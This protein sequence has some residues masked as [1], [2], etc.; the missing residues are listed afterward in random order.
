[1]RPTSIPFHFRCTTNAR[2][3]WLSTSLPPSAVHSR[4]PV[5][6]PLACS[7]SSSPSS[8]IPRARPV[9]CAPLA[10]VVL[11]LGPSP[12]D[13]LPQQ[14]S[15]LCKRAVHAQLQPR[16]RRVYVAAWAETARYRKT[17]AHGTSRHRVL[18]PRADGHGARLA[19]LNEEGALFAGTQASIPLMDDDVQI[20]PVLDPV[21]IPARAPDR[22]HAH[23]PA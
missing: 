9:P 20:G 1:M 5:Y 3:S 18:R 8:C 17:R 7:L 11:S 13:H 2:T 16:H 21:V 23:R 10:L 4:K 12:P 6:S 22:F 19:L 14:R 15:G